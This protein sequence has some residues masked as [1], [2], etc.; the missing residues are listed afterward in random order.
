[1]V[2]AFVI[3]T[4]T[5]GEGEFVVGGCVVAH[6]CGVSH[7]HCLLLDPVTLRVPYPPCEADGHVLAQL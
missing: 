1:M 5:V 6:V 4:A 3:D 2:G 7:V